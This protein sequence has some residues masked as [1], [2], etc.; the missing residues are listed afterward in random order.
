MEEWVIITIVVSC[1]LVL[2]LVIYIFCRH[3]KKKQAYRRYLR[4][5]ANVAI[6]V[7]EKESLKG[8]DKETAQQQD[9]GENQG[10][11]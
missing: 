11:Q 1:I 7:D 2:C 3:W 6:K 5:H 8:E 10:S 9:D 4:R